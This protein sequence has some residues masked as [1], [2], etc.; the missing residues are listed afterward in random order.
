MTGDTPPTVQSEQ[1]SAEARA[2]RQEA[3]SRSFIMIQQEHWD[4]QGAQGLY[5]AP[6][7]C[8]HVQ[9]FCVLMYLQPDRFMLNTIYLNLYRGI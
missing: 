1:E 8:T 6:Y 5:R 3:A 7:L 4:G 2:R 9:C